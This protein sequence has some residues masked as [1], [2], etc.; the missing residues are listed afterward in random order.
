M[1]KEELYLQP[2]NKESKLIAATMYALILFLFLLIIFFNLFSL[3]TVLGPSMENT[4]TDHQRVL[5]FR[6]SSVDAG[7]IVV[8]KGDS[9]GFKNEN[10]IK[11]VI[12]VGGESFLF[13]AVVDDP[14]FDLDKHLSYPLSVYVNRGDGFTLLDESDRDLAA[15][16]RYYYRGNIKVLK[17][18]SGD[19]VLTD[20]S[21]EYINS[22]PE[23]SYFV[24]GDNRI[25]SSDSRTHG[26][27][28]KKDVVG[29]VVAQ[30][31][32]GSAGEKFFRFV[33]GDVGTT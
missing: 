33:Y 14:D 32:P 15:P 18:L 7:S 5:L 3:C 13:A 8:F 20:V 22:V 6:D 21:G 26:F 12:A 9:Y 25:N 4:L 10:I 1:K 31:K 28:Q 16:V 29:V 30:L 11:R 17:I 23:G 2:D 27:V 24:M 19:P